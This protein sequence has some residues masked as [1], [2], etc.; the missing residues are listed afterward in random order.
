MQIIVT[1]LPIEDAVD[2]A[3][4]RF[5]QADE[6]LTQTLAASSRG[7]PWIALGVLASVAGSVVLM[8]VFPLPAEAAQVIGTLLLVFG[9]A[10]LGYG[11]PLWSR[12]RKERRQRTREWRHALEMVHLREQQAAEDPALTVEVLERVDRQQPLLIPGCNAHTSA[13]SKYVQ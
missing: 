12:V 5:G 6:R 3:R 4:S 7:L 11:L 2:R 9:G 1:E 8:G 13:T 10:F